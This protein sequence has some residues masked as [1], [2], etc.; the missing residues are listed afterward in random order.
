MVNVKVPGKLYLAGEYAVVEPGTPAVIVAVNRFV[1]LKIT[2][3]TETGTIYSHQYQTLPVKWHRTA[4]RQ[5]QLENDVQLEFVL[6]AIRLT[7]R[8]AAECGHQLQLFNLEIDSELDSDDGKKFGLGSSAAVTVGVVKAIAAF[9]HL[10]LTALE[11]YKIAALAHYNVQGN[12]SLG[13]IA[14]SAFTGWI[15]Y[16]SPDRNWLLDQPQTPLKPLIA[17]DWPELKIQPLTPPTTADLIVGWTGAPASTKHL[18]AEVKRRSHLKYNTF[19][20][21]SAQ[22]VEKLVQAIKNDDFEEM[23]AA[24]THNRQLLNELSEISHVELETPRLKE[25]VELVVRFGGSGKMSGAGGGDCGIGF[26]KH[27]SN[28]QQIF[29][30]WRQAQIL[31]LQLSTYTNNEEQ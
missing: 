8:Y 6:E 16:Y 19:V 17:A 1:H 22:C 4:H 7:E 2:S 20:V 30:Q 11:I 5:I 31:P 18:V 9:Y 10:N 24:I 26:V 13:D 27:G 29:E 12:G 21:Q 23:T 15:A 28:Y 14:A 25:L 3:S